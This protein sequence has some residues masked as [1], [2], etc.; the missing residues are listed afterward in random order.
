MTPNSDPISPIIFNY[1]ESNNSF[2]KSGLIP[3]LVSYILQ[4]PY[5]FITF[6]E[7]PKL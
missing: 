5:I 2:G 7:N 4:A 3:D 1:S 6:G